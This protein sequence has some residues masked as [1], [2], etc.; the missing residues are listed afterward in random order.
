METATQVIN[1]KTEL[2]R[3]LIALR[4]QMQRQHN[5]G[6]DTYVRTSYPEVRR[7][8]RDLLAIDPEACLYE[9]LGPYVP[10]ESP[11]DERRT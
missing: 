9:G 2:Q 10:R 8:E 1:S 3:R 7:L 6:L 4:K 5:L 11:F